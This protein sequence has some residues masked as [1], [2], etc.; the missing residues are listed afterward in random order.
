MTVLLASPRRQGDS[1]G[2]NALGD[3]LRARRDTLKA[4]GIGVRKLVDGVD[5]AN[6]TVYEYLDAHK[7][8]KTFPRH[9]TLRK[10]AE[11]FQL[12][13]DEVIQ[14]A[15]AST[16]V[17]GGNP[18]QLVLQAA[19]LETGRTIR[20]AARKATRAGCPIS[21]STISELI[22]GNTWNPTEDTLKALVIG[23]DLD[24]KTLD[25]AANQTRAKVMYRLPS[26]I[27]Q[28]LTPERWAKIVKMVEQAL[29]LGSD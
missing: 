16:Q 9:S 29:D 28:Q 3:L 6:S 10:L 26:H 22:N 13:L 2:M 11:G 1:V 4:R 15:R 21:E 14:A 25:D 18:L 20:E 12:D 23:F 17:I 7:P 5:L 27:E 19:Q 24:R 8:F